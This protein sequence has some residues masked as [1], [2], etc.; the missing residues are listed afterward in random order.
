M[1]IN[2]VR[3]SGFAAFSFPKLYRLNPR[4]WGLGLIVFLQSLN[5]YTIQKLIPWLRQFVP[6]LAKTIFEP[7]RCL[8]TVASFKVGA[9]DELF[10]D[11]LGMVARA[12]AT[13]RPTPV[14]AA[15]G[16][17]L[18]DQSGESSEAVLSSSPMHPKP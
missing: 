6:S 5:L 1:A 15:Q 7:R 18:A 17:P 12:A 2:L 4:F 13:G 3:G 8:A 16:S 11:C 14:G 10:L 9:I